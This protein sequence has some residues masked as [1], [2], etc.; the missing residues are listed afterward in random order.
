MFDLAAGLASADSDGV[1]TEA[2]A[3]AAIA[4]YISKTERNRS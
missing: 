1:V 3:E 4:E 2:E